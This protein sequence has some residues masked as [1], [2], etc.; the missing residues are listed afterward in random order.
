[1]L[2]LDYSRKA[3]EWIP[4]MYGGNEN[5][6]AISFLKEFNETVYREYPDTITI[7]RNRRLGRVCRAP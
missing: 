4:N 7:A 3:N 2:Y 5:L 6:E 1:M